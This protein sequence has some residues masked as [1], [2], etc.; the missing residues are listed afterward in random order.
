MEELGGQRAG[1]GVNGGLLG[2]SEGGAGGGEAVGGAFELGLADGLGGVLQGDDGGD[3]VARLQALK[4]ELDL[5]G[6]IFR[7]RRTSVA[8]GEVGCGDLL[9]VVDV[10]D[11]AAFD[12]VHARINVAGDGDVDEEHG[13]VAAA[14]GIAG[15]GNG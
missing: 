6:T 10:V 13:A 14:R 3:G 5:A 12:L 7:R 4:V 15:R 2:G 11:E 8:V 1:E 9:E